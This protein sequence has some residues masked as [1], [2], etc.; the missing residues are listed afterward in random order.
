V[1]EVQR[2]IENIVT[3][4]TML[5]MCTEMSNIKSMLR[6]YKII[7]VCNKSVDCADFLKQIYE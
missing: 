4:L 5:I 1:F 6:S 7:Y 3:Y 2:Y